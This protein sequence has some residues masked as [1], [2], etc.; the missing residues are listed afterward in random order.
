MHMLVSHLT[1]MQNPYICVAGFKVKLPPQ[2][3]EVVVGPH[4]RPVLPHKERLQ[5]KLLGVF[6][7]GSIVDLDVTGLVG[8]PPEIEDYSFDPASIS[9]VGQMPET[10]FW[11]TLVDNMK[12][13]LT[14]IFGSYIQKRSTKQGT[15]A[16]VSV[17]TGIASLG[18]FQ[19][20]KAP[21]L[22]LNEYGKLRIRVEDP[23]FAELNLSVTDVRFCDPDKPDWELK[24]DV[25]DKVEGLLLKSNP[26]DIALGVGLARELEG[27]HWLQ[28]N[29]VFVKE[30]PLWS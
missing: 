2:T 4:I 21:K 1:R 3:G 19:P 9:V 23:E 11:N 27:F 7:L 8:S 30:N 14:S 28:V 16:V 25:F 24:K 29:N 22:F 12:S 26:Q 18:E 13:S 5:K 20:I 10:Q 6:Q 17:G 15:G